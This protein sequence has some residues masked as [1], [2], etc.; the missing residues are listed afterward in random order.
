MGVYVA[1]DGRGREITTVVAPNLA[2][3]IPT[4]GPPTIVPT[5]PAAA[6]PAKAATPVTLF[7]CQIASPIP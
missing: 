7:P 4:P 6:P 1:Q 5:I 3:V 2:A